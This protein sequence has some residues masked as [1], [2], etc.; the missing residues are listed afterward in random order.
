MQLY[1]CREGYPLHVYEFRIREDKITMQSLLAVPYTYHMGLTPLHY[2]YWAF[3]TDY[4]LPLPYI[5]PTH[6]MQLGPLQRSIARAA[7]G[8]QAPAGAGSPLTPGSR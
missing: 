5:T 7:A 8:H 2:S 1:D 6:Y 4:R 3:I